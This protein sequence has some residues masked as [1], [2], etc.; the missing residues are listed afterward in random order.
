[1]SEE[2]ECEK[3]MDWKIVGSNIGTGLPNGD[4]GNGGRIRRTACIGA[5][6]K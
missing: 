1:M 4:S 2:D 3:K 6:W 5:K